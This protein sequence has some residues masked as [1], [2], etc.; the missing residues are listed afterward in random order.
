MMCKDTWFGYLLRTTLVCLLGLLF[1]KLT[2]GFLISAVLHLISDSIYSGLNEQIIGVI[3]SNGSFLMIIILLSVYTRNKEKADLYTLYFSRQKNKIWMTV[4]GSLTGTAL[5]LSTVL[6]AWLCGDL[7]LK[8]N[9]V[10][11]LVIILVLFSAIIQG[12]A[13]EILFRGY[14]LE[15]IKQNHSANLAIVISSILFGI[16][17]ILNPEI[18]FLGVCNIIV[19]GFVFSYLAFK[20]NSINFIIAMHVMWNFTQE[21]ILG[22]PNSGIAF[23]KPVFA[24][25]KS[26]NS[27]FYNQEFGVEA[28][29]QMFIIWSIVFLIMLVGD[30]KAQLTVK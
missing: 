22:L 12:T 26:N 11:I 25:I 17:H 29:L 28:S 6:V 5:C 10:D 23:S 7:V 19:V 30:N 18:T 21:V 3:T 8:F 9:T 20:L 15:G 14:L 24:I 16:L 27:L 4:L 2:I 13:E 1:G